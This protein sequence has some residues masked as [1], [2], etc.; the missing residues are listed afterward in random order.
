[1]RP[2]NVLTLITLVLALALAGC[3]R[4]HVNAYGTD[5]DEEDPPKEEQPAEDPGD[6]YEDPQEGGDNE[7]TLAALVVAER[8]TG[9]WRG[10][11]DVEYFDQE[12]RKHTDKEQHD[13]QLMVLVVGHLLVV[14]CDVVE[15]VYA[16]EVAQR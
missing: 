12:Q 10:Q 3:E 4:E 7:Q 15:N 1:M 13:A 6:P 14:V 5:P 2:A 11:L 9:S 16:L 8:L